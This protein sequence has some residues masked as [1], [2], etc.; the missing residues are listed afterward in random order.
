MITT[1]DKINFIQRVFG[2]CVISRDGINV[3]VKCPKCAS[4]GD[5]K[6]KF[7]IRIDTDQCH[8]WICGLKSGSLGQIL[9][10]FFSDAI[11]REY[12]DKFSTVKN[13]KISLISA[14]KEEKKQI[15]LPDG[16]TLLAKNNFKDPDMKDCLKYLLSRNI[17]KRDMWYYKFGSCTKGRFRRRVI[18]PSFDSSGKLNYFT[19]RTIDKNVNPKYYNSNVKK[20][21]LIFNESNIDWKKSI[22]LVEGPFDLVRCDD[23]ATCLLGSNLSVSSQLFQTIVKNNISVILA[24][25][26]DMFDKTQHFARLFS[27][28]GILVKILNLNNFSDV[29]EMSKKEFLMSKK[30]AVEWQASDRLFHLIRSIKS[31]SKL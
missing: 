22:T 20:S 4:S 18:M 27:S 21:D 7:S 14:H 1:Q 16:F 17:S 11:V 2:P 29:G 12:Y 24:L 5:Q 8:C 25:D 15:T 30:A 13:R 19:A 28:Y 9:S 26:S 31:G 3:A 6:R 10:K 23:N